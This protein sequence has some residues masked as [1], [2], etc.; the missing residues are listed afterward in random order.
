MYWFI[1]SLV[2]GPALL[3]LAIYVWAKWQEKQLNESYG[4]ES[5]WEDQL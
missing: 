4:K 2:V 1:A 3:W 5:N